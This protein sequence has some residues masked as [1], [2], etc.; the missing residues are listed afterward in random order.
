MRV[1]PVALLGLAVLGG[2]GAAMADELVVDRGLPIINLNNAAGA[3]RSNVA[4]ADSPAPDFFGDTFT[5]PSVD[6]AVYTINSLRTWVVVRDAQ[7]A[8]DLT[9]KFTTIQLFT[10]TG[11]S[12]SANSATVGVSLSS[13]AGPADYERTS[14][15]FYKIF[16]L[17]FTGVNIV[18]N[19]GSTINF[20]VAGNGP[21]P[22]RDWFNAASNAALS[23]SPQDSADNQMQEYEWDGSATAPSFL[24]TF[25]SNAPGVWDKSSDLNVQVFAEV[26]EPASMALLGAGIAGLGWARRRRRG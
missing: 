10:G 17:D 25:D 7:T 8:T 22:E 12:L 23:G 4:W 21:G 20:G 14:G 1:L 26:P 6:G 11:N 13:Y 2:S 16:Q 3:N 18:A 24:G 15:G 9:T 19:A 5:L